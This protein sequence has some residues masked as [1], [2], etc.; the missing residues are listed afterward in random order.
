MRAELPESAVMEIVSRALAEDI[1]PGDITTFSTVDADAQSRA[2]IVAKADGVIAGLPVAALTVRALDPRSRF[3]DVLSD[4]L[5]VSDGMAVARL[6]GRTA[7]LL[8]AERTAL[9]FLQRLSGIATLTADFVEAIRG[10]D[11]RIVDTRKT[12]PGLRLLDKYAVRMGGGDNHRLGLYDG[13]LIK[14]NHLRAV[15][16]V[17]EAVARARANAHH[18]LKIE[19]EVQTLEE[20]G[21]ALAAE[22][23]VILLD[24][25]ALDEIEQS[26][27]LVA[28]RCLLEV[29]GGVDLPSVRALA[30]TG[31][32]LISVGA[33][34]HSAPALDLSLE[35][36][37]D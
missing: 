22:A 16:G 32:D 26:V 25:M 27:Q 13:V 15:G 4:G 9:N 21:E 6:S 33:L 10:T 28:G 11:A 8:T 31:V 36:A 14:D 5:R 7:A 35:I 18:L 29:S 17:G 1:G 23:D 24:N 34:T 2:E 37:D 19:V 12:A 3:E 20:V 30:E